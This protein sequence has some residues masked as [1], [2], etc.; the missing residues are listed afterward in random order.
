MTKSPSQFLEQAAQPEMLIEQN[1]RL[2]FI[3]NKTPALIGYWDSQLINQFS[4][5]AYSRWF[6]KSPEQIKGQHLNHLLGD[7]IY[8][9]LLSEI[10]GALNGNEQRFERYLIDA[11]TG[12]KIHTLTRYL[13]DIV[14]DRVIGFLVLGTDVT[15]V[16]NLEQLA[17]YDNLTGLPSRLLL[18]DRI[19]QAMSRVKRQGGFVAVLF[20]DLDGF[21]FI[22]DHYGHDVGD[23]FLIAISQQMK[24]AIRDTER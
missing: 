8:T 12:E 13:P 2:N 22:N 18:M 20:V 9:G 15:D 7:D 16:K 21:K 5:D 4:N 1:E 23:E 17:Y 24:K 14:N 3:L 6:G 19:N 11:N 10:E